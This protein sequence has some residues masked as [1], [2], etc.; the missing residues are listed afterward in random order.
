MTLSATAQPDE[1]RPGDQVPEDRHSPVRRCIASGEVRDKSE[2]LRFV[3]GPDGMVVPDL[4]GKLPGRGLWLLARRDVLDKACERNLFARAAKAPLRVP[5]DLADRVAQG[6]R[7]RCLD[8][9]GLAR[10]AG[11]LAVG[12]EKARSQLSRELAGVLIQAADGAPGGRQK[13]SALAR[14]VAPDL[15]VVAIFTAAELGRV[16]GRDS[17]VHVIMG[18]GRMAD[19]FAAAAARYSAMA[20]GETNRIMT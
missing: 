13:L 5:A 20:A 12:Y 15:P 2:L 14:G 17:T 8:L 9:I 7:E 1:L 19:R 16:T 18:P 6:L 4:S 3:A 10:R 11:V